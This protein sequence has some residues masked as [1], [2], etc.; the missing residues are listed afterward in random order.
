MYAEESRRESAARVSSSKS[1]SFLKCAALDGVAKRSVHVLLLPSNHLR[2]ATFALVPIRVSPFVPVVLPR[3]NCAGYHFQPEITSY[4]P[5]PTPPSFTSLL[6]NIRTSF[7]SPQIP[8]PG[9]H[10]EHATNLTRTI[11]CT[12]TPLP[13]HSPHPLSSHSHPLQ[14]QPH[15][16]PPITA[17]QK[18]QHLPRRLVSGKGLRLVWHEGVDV[19]DEAWRGILRWGSWGFV[20]GGRSWGIVLW[21]RRKDADVSAGWGLDLD[22]CG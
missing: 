15:H 9:I 14:P 17:L 18:K 19:D 13:F 3:G 2:L 22:G 12:L 11:S 21:G 1:G 16:A 20:M 6:R 5:S 7:P 10:Q 8:T 4:S